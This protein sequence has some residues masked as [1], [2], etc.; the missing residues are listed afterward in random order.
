MLE[1]APA[2]VLF[3]G[4]LGM[5]IVV[6]SVLGMTIAE[7]RVHRTRP[8]A[9]RVVRARLAPPRSS[10]R[11]RLSKARPVPVVSGR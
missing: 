8:P 9:R 11:Q 5:V 1:V 7:R 2:S 6:Y 10:P 3:M 4:L